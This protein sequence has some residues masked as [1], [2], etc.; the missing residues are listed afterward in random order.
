[1]GAGKMMQ[2]YDSEDGEP[3]RFVYVCIEKDLSKILVPVIKQIQ[4][5]YDNQEVVG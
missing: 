3:L 5:E 1:M 2:T 4:D